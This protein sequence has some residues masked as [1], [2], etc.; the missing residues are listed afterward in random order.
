MFVSATSSLYYSDSV[1]HQLYNESGMQSAT[2]N[3]TAANEYDDIPSGS[4]SSCST[5]ASS[6][7]YA[8]NSSF[9]YV[10]CVCNDN[11]RTSTISADRDDVGVCS[12]GFDTVE[13]RVTRKIRTRKVRF[14]LSDDND[15]ASLEMPSCVHYYSN[16][17]V[18]H[19]YEYNDDS[20]WWSV[21][22]ED[23]MFQNV[24]KQCRVIRAEHRDTLKSFFQCYDGIA[25][26]IPIDSITI[27]SEIQKWL[28]LNIANDSTT[29]GLEGTVAKKF[30]RERQQIIHHILDCY[31]AA[32]HSQES[33]TCR[34]E[35]VRSY[36]TKLSYATCIFAQ[37]L[38]LIDE[39]D[40]RQDCC[41][42]G[43]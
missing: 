25:S 28:S 38:A 37:Q 36:S 9:D 29:R 15:D 24:K 32:K 23:L 34:E 1:Q 8:S 20:L 41:R 13:S 33:L 19:N 21:N 31:K 43:Y 2:T 22:E 30:K 6:V 39:R 42:S 11:N 4:L 5:D 3:T 12:T 17:F 10:T 40:A 14:T 7:P 26:E 16:D 18:Q 27:Q 35:I